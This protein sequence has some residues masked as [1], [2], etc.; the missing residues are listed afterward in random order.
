[1]WWTWILITL[2]GIFLLPII[3]VLPFWVIEKLLP[4][5]TQFL[6]TLVTLVLIGGMVVFLPRLMAPK[7]RK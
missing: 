2:G 4:G 7:E 1:V 5:I 3:A 6:T